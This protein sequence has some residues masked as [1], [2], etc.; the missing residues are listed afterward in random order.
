VVRTRSDSM[1][2]EN[3]AVLKQHRQVFAQTFNHFQIWKSLRGRARPG[4]CE[5]DGQPFCGFLYW[6][7]IT[8][9]LALTP[10]HYRRHQ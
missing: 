10:R 2:S 6:R 3:L 4:M 7:A 5:R 8:G 9:P 1:N